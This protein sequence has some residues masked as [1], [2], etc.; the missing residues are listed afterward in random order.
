MTVLTSALSNMIEAPKMD[1]WSHW[2]TLTLHVVG[3]AM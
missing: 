2:T 3:R 1:V